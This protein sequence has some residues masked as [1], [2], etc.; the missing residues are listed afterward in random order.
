VTGPRSNDSQFDY[1]E[2]AF[3]IPA[4]TPLTLMV[5][6]LPPYIPFLLYK[7]VCPTLAIPIPVHGVDCVTLII[8]NRGEMGFL[9]VNRDGIRNFFQASSQISQKN[10]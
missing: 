1:L 6:S 3:P 10:L 5:S 7:K 4:G 2:V 9:S 8:S